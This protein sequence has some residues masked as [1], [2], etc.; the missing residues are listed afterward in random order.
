M[1]Q[2]CRIFLLL[3]VSSIIEDNSCLLTLDV[4]RTIGREQTRTQT[5]GQQIQLYPIGTEVVKFRY[6]L[7]QSSSV[8]KN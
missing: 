6:S 7:P 1:Q 5:S 3:R 8:P 4:I 2:D